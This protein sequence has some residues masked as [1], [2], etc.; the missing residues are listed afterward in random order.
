LGRIGGWPVA[1]LA[2]ECLEARALLSNIAVTAQAGVVTLVGDTAD[3]TLAASVVKGQL[4]LAGTNGTTLTFNGTTAA[5]VDVPLPA[6]LKAIHIDLPGA[7]NNSVTFDAL[8]LPKVAGNFT[9]N[10]GSGIDSFSL[11]NASVGGGV[12]VNAGNGDDT[13]TLAN[14]TTGEFSIRAGN[15]VDS[16]QL[17]SDTTREV[18]I[19]SGNG[20][21]KIGITNDTTGPV[22][23]HAGNGDN[24]IALANDTL[25]RVLIGTGSGA[26]SIK[27]TSDMTGRVAINSGSGNDSILLS[28]VTLQA[29]VQLGDQDTNGGDD[30]N[31][32]HGDDQGHGHGEDQGNG[33]GNGQGN[34]QGNDNGDDQGD[35][36]GDDTGGEDDHDDESPRTLLAINTGAGD[37][38]VV[39][40]SVVGMGAGVRGS[41][42]QISLGTGNNTLIMNSD[43]D[44][45]FLHVTA[46]GLGNN[47]VK[48][49]NSTFG[50]NVVVTLPD[51][52]E[53]I[54]L[55]GDMFAGPVTLSTGTGSDSTIAV[56]DSTFKSR[57][58]FH[59][60]GDN[61]QLDLETAN[62]VGSGTEFHGPVIANLTGASA[63]PN[64]GTNAVGNAL[65]FDKLLK[66]TGGSPE[67][68]VTVADANTT[69]NGPVV[70]KNANRMDV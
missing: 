26:D 70:L 7:E 12:I 23:V 43:T 31:A 1:T 28:N 25:G 11:T 17:G 22:F 61:A 37:D 58:K 49:S 36:H 16:I 66:I 69:F 4:E 53:Q 9:V 46:Q 62:S 48:I 44:P 29:K 67:A 15:G 32:P 33:N 65:I 45:G 39:L 38:N 19:K 3:H 34:D 8:G 41:K 42:W 68:L 21:D 60:A 20:G 54:A 6:K 56:D 51:G 52:K 5:T 57:V 14:D 64:L 18:E 10:L 24:T 13:I 35:D 27:L 47:V 55:T 40:D 50:K 30:S 59:M 2:A 63:A